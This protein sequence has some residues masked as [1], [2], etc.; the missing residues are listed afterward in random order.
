MN[1]REDSITGDHRECRGTN[2]SVLGLPT[3]QSIRLELE[4]EYRKVGVAITLTVITFN[5][6]IITRWNFRAPG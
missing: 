1:E 5:S 4:K 6:T 2:G 3:D